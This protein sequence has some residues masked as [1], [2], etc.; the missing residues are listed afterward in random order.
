MKLISPDIQKS[1][2]KIVSNVSTDVILDDLGD[3]LFAIL[4]D[5]SLDISIKEQMIVVLRCVNNKRIV[6]QQFLGVFSYFKY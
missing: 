4:I 2:V 6:I 3:Y 1:I 5:E